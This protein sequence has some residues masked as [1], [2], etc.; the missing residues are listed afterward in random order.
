MQ[1]L[2][3]MLIYFVIGCL[4]AIWLEGFTTRN[5]EDPY[6]KPCVNRERVIHIFF[7]PVTL[8]IFLHSFLS[9]L[10]KK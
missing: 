10:F 5:L 9:D 1:Y 6:N 2:E 4:W 7:W 8:A 3:I